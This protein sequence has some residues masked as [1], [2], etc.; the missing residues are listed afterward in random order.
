MFIP[1]ESWVRILGLALVRSDNKARLYD[2]RFFKES[3]VTR[4]DMFKRLK[5]YFTFLFLFL[6]YKQ[7]FRHNF[8]RR[9]GGNICIPQIRSLTISG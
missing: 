3:S 7:E 4:S 1:S 8:G 5:Y 2:A 9:R 6:R